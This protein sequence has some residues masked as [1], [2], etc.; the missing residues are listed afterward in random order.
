MA[1]A[2]FAPKRLG[3]LLAFVMVACLGWRLYADGVLHWAEIYTYKTT[4]CRMDSIA[5]GCFATVLQRSRPDLMAWLRRHGAAVF[6]AGVALVLA[7]LLYRDEFFRNT[8]RYSLQSLGMMALVLPLVEGAPR[9]GWVMAILEWAPLRWMGKR[10]YGAYVWHYTAMTFAAYLLHVKGELEF[11][12]LHNRLLAIP[13][14]IAV[15]WLLAAVSYALVFKP[16][17][18]F[19]PLLQ[20][21]ERSAPAGAAVLAAE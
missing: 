14:T 2:A 17:Q 12:S 21:R 15:D 1:A 7:T 4:E 19:K 18:R 6:A 10:S 13:P 20:P 11:S 9:L 16:P 3:W 5:W 8:W